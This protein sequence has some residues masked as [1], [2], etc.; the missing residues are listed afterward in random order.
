MENYN[1]IGGKEMPRILVVD[2]DKNVRLLYKYTLSLEG[3]EVVTAH[4]REAAL[5][6]LDGVDLVVSELEDPYDDNSG[7]FSKFYETN[8]DLKVVVNTGYPLEYTDST[9]CQADAILAKT[10]DTDRLTSVIRNVLQ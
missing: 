7:N 3:F 9:L 2:E 8:K 5:Q 6:K 1:Y 4:S 10:S